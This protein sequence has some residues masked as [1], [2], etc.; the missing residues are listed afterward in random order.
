MPAWVLPAAM[1]AGN[2][3]SQLFGQHKQNEKN[4][5]LAE[6]E[7]RRNMEM[8]Q[9]QLDWN[10]PV[11]QMKRF[12]DA[13]LNPNLI[14]GQG[15]PGNMEKAPEYRRPDYAFQMPAVAQAYQQARLLQAQT[16]LTEVKTDESTI[17]QDLMRSQNNLVKANPY[18]RKEYVDSLVTQLSSTAR[19]KEQEADW[20]TGVKSFQ[21][22]D[23]ELHGPAGAVKMEAQ[24]NELINRVGLQNADKKIKAE[25]LQSKEFQNALQ[26]L[27]VKWMKDGDITPQH[28]Y[29]GIMLLLGK[30]MQ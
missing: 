21:V 29:Q 3:M 9:Y 22:G 8:T 18:M 12:R 27:Q 15:S 25:I 23:R 17:K 28:I 7:F 20:A 26:E 4:A 6:T 5:E 10:S 14:Y 1:A 16:D 19:L 11:N 13:G 2:I 30:L 24:L